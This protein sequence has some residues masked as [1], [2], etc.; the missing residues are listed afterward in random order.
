MR[1][2][3]FEVNKFEVDKFEVDKFEVDKFENIYNSELIQSSFTFI[4]YH[5]RIMFPS[6][7]FL[8]FE[9]HSDEPKFFIQKSIYKKVYTK[10]YIMINIYLYLTLSI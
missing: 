6:H 2:T 7:A 9:L 8:R 10:K 3:S 1:C 5:Y 4:F